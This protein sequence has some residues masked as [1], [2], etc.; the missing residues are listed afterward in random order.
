[1]AGL[2]HLGIGLA[3]SLLVPE[4]HPLILIFCSYLLD[5]IFLVFMLL[6]L[7]DLPQSDRVVEAPW[8]HSLFM[9]LCWSGIAGIVTF[10]ITSSVY[11]GFILG[12][13]V[14]SHWI[15]DFIVSPMTY[16]FP[17]DTGKLIHPFGGS[18]K[19]GLGVMRTKVGVIA[20]EG[21]VTIL[22]GVLFLLTF[23]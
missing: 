3:F 11:F 14:F 19:V 7:E 21:G 6:G 22:G 10:I 8:S 23:I 18:A 16:A 4:I 1:M 12:V 15:V 5:I 17:N 9:A 2:A 20:I 13:L